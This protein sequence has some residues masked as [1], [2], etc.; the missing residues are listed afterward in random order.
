[1]PFEKKV[2]MHHSNVL[3]ALVYD[4][5]K[6]QIADANAKNEDLQRELIAKTKQIETLQNEL[7]SISKLYSDENLLQ[8][9]QMNRLVAVIL[10]EKN[11]SVVRFEMKIREQSDRLNILSKKSDAKDLIIKELKEKNGRLK[12]KMFSKD[13]SSYSNETIDD[14][15]SKQVDKR[16]SKNKRKE[17]NKC[18][19]IKYISKDDFFCGSNETI[20]SKSKYVRMLTLKNS[21][22]SEKKNIKKDQSHSARHDDSS[23][24]TNKTFNSESNFVGHRTLNNSRDNRKKNKLE[25]RPTSF[26][27]GRKG[28]V[29]NMYG[30]PSSY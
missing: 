23:I 8:L 10:E 26:N 19:K 27:Y 21:F 9:E 7:E 24:D 12:I 16:A 22:D 18:L 4:D 14:S 2:T 30:V 13:D 3:Q 1:V 11:Q 25:E 15:S 17:G 20:D 29:N 6:S 28:N 5:N